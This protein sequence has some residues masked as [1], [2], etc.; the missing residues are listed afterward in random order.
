M[1]GRRDNI[2]GRGENADYQH[3]LHFPQCFQKASSSESSKPRIVWDRFNNQS[4]LKV[5]MVLGHTENQSK[6]KSF[7]AG[8]C[9]LLD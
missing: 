2:V 9:R 1:A 6:A 7:N 3:F 8:L 5:T 4:N